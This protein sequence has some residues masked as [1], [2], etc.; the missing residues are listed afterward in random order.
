MNISS[1]SSKSKLYG[2]YL[3]LSL[4]VGLLYACV[5]VNS[6]GEKTVQSISTKFALTHLA[7]IGA[8]KF[9]FTMVTR[10]NGAAG[11]A[12]D[13]G[14]EAVVRGGQMSMCC[15]LTEISLIITEVSYITIISS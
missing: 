6:T 3:P 5:S 2:K 13:T 15:F 4:Y 9:Q 14:I 8:T 11:R 1:L 12:G 7:T 10:V